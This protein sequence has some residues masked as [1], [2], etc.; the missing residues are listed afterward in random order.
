MQESGLT[1]ILSLI[2]CLGRVSWFCPSWIPSG[3]TV[4]RGCSGLSLAGHGTLPLLV[5]HAAFLIHTPKLSHTCESNKTDS[6]V[7]D[8]I[9]THIFKTF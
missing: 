7:P 6:G 3:G 8:T 1:E 9:P 2:G 5:W 4:G